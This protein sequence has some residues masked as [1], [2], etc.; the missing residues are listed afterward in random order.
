MDIDELRLRGNNLYSIRDYNSAIDVYTQALEVSPGNAIIL[1][2]RSACY[3]AVGQPEK[4][5]FDARLAISIEPTFVKCYFRLATALKARDAFQEA[6]EVTEL[7]LIQDPQSAA[8]KS[9]KIA[10]LKEY[11]AICANNEATIKVGNTSAGASTSSVSSTAAISIKRGFLQNKD[12]CNK[13]VEDGNSPGSGSNERRMHSEIKSLIKKV[14]TGGFGADDMKKHMLQGVFKQLME[15]ETFTE[16]LFPGAPK[17]VLK[18]LPKNMKD[19]LAWDILSLDLS[20]IAKKAARVYE[21]IKSKGAERGEYMDATSEAILVPQ[22]V[23]E[24]FARDIVE[25]VRNLGKKVSGLNA[26][27]SLSLALPSEDEASWDQIEMEVSCALGSKENA[28]GVQ[29][30]F[31]GDEWAALVMEDVKRYVRDEKMSDMNTCNSLTLP[32]TPID[33]DSTISPPQPPNNIA[34]TSSG[35]CY[36][37]T[38]NSQQS[39]SS[40]ARMAWVESDDLTGSYPA[41]TELVQQLHALP[42]EI[43]AKS[44]CALRLLRPS[45]GCTMLVYYPEGSQQAMRLD[46][47]EGEFDSGIRVTCAYHLVPESRSTAN[48]SRAAPVAQLLYSAAGDKNTTNQQSSGQYSSDKSSNGHH[49]VTACSDEKEGSLLQRVDIEHDQLIVHQSLKV[50][51]A[52]SKAREPFYALLFFIHGK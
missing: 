8:L 39:R 41:L 12:L 9:L 22:I 48:E 21:G 25:T 46:N 29:P 7:G 32:T 43:N 45:R 4:A 35:S 38:N 23:E 10:C 37:D 19:L 31:L 20:K 27:V 51:N 6:I 24:A 13:D 16:V 17:T 11:N 30:D 52:R 5:E 36:T 2:N 15:I 1:G 14:A 42:Y 44:D 40:S 18:D 47:R 33:L 3:L 49:S 26:K 34:T 28:L 50:Q